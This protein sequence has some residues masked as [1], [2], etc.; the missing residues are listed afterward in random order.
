[1]PELN[2]N[3][4]ASFLPFSRQNYKPKH[5]V[6][7]VAPT[8]AQRQGSHIQYSYLYS[9]LF[10]KT[11]E[12]IRKS[13]TS[14]M[15]CLRNSDS[16][17][18]SSSSSTDESRWRRVAIGLALL[19]CACFALW[20]IMDASFFPHD[21][22]SS[23]LIHQHYPIMLQDEEWA[24]QTMDDIDERGRSLLRGKGLLQWA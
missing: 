5:F 3:Y 16:S 2:S 23:S 7:S 24:K 1:M 10:V 20:K 11:K 14:S 22:G 4:S 8:A 21:G 19:I 6:L 9:H 17:S 18:S 12:S 15:A 13:N